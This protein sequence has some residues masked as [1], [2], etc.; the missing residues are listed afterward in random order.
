MEDYF[1]VLRH[2]DESLEA[3][4]P[5]IWNITNKYG[6]KNSKERILIST[7]GFNPE[8]FKNKE[9]LDIISSKLLEKIK[10]R[11]T[12]IDFDKVILNGLSAKFEQWIPA[13]ILSQEIK[14]C[15]SNTKI[16]IGGFT[17]I[18]ICDFFLERFDEFDYAIYGEGEYSLLE[19]C[20]S[21]QNGTNLNKI[22]RLLYK[23]YKNIIK[24]EE[25]KSNYLD[26][27]NY[28][29]PNYSDYINYIKK[30]KIKEYGFP[31]NTNRRCNWGK[32]N[33][34]AQYQGFKYRERNNECIVNEMELLHEKYKSTFFY[35]CDANTIGLNINK[36]KN[37]CSKIIESAN[38]RK[39]SYNLQACIIPKN[40]NSDVIQKMSLAG[41]RNLFSGYEANTDKMLSY[42]NKSHSFADNIL[43]LKFSTKYKIQSDIPIISG[44]IEEK[45][46]D[47]H[48]AIENLNYVRFFTYKRT[49][50]DL[51]LIIYYNTHYYNLLSNL[52]KSE[53]DLWNYNPIS[54]LLP[55]NYFKFKDRFLFF[56]YSRIPKNNNFYWSYYL[57]AI[58][59]LKSICY[60]YKIHNINNIYRYNE[61]QNNKL[62]TSIEFDKPLYIE[63]LKEANNR[64][65]SVD[66]LF[67][68]L[69]L[70]EDKKITMHELIETIKELKNEHILYANTDYSEII[71]IVDTDQI[72]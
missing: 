11:L 22:P 34:C 60:S 51:P 69:Y 65:I 20:Q 67:K 17:K 16:V 14:K 70:N 8:S 41:F 40:L 18:E 5:F 24:S 39:V 13:S 52:E 62:I 30:Y 47:V 48:E 15:N 57:M 49:F 53:Q 38:K 29:Y 6:C 68:R 42:L 12:Q 59:K 32:C 10:N 21:L 58:R 43:F 66:D 54:Y 2:K 56:G 3:L 23:E 37:L 55:D 35:F 19:L 33:F 45:S 72:L 4:L 31:I 50:L 7:F 25:T 46:S 27:D 9:K 44:L 63:I 26:F 61:Y 64:V 28:I 1:S 71:S 36:F